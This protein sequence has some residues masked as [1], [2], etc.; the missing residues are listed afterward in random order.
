MRNI[1]QV[2]QLG[3]T[4]YPVNR[5]VI[6]CGD[7]NFPNIDWS[8]DNCLKQSNISFTGVFLNLF[9]NNGLEQLVS[10][11]T[12]LDNVLDLVLCNDANCI[13]DTRVT[14]PFS[15]S[16]HNTV[17]F[18]IMFTS[19]HSF[20][21]EEFSF[22]DFN[23]ADWSQIQLYLGDIDF[24]TL[25]TSDETIESKFESFYAILFNCLELYVP[26]RRVTKDKRTR[27]AT[28]P[29]GIRKLQR[30][31]A[32]AWRIYHE[33]HTPESLC[34]YKMVALQCRSAVR[35][36]LAKREKSLIDNGNIGSFFR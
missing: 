17:E 14:S 5:T 15:T 32:T 20:Y 1:S 36:F 24:D 6:I 9:Y 34:S 31:K 7:F 28:Y 4:L 23:H 21:D 8:A 3:D 30:K 11:P 29:P 13:V 2:T 19:T 27:S 16:D 26:L 10:S 18:K 35:A 33:F 25:F 22:Y 12:R